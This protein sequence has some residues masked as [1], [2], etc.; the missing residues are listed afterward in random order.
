MTNIRILIGDLVAACRVLG[1]VRVIAAG[2]MY[3]TLELDEIGTAQ[4]TKSKIGWTLD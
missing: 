3:A 4:L 1:D 2:S